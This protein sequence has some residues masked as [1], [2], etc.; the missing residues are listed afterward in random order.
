MLGLQFVSFTDR[1]YLERKISAS[2]KKR[3][4]K[5]ADSAL[6]LKTFAEMIYARELDL[7]IADSKKLLTQLSAS[8]CIDIRDQTATML[9]FYN[10]KY[11]MVEGEKLLE[12][13]FT[14]LLNDF[15]THKKNTPLLIRKTNMAEMV[16]FFDN[17]E[18]KNGEIEF[19]E[20]DPNGTRELRSSAPQASLGGPTTSIITSLFAGMAK[21]VGNKIGADIFDTIFPNSKNEME[22]ILAALQ[23]NIKEIFREE[24]DKQTIDNLNYQICGII[25]Y[26]QETYIPLKNDAGRDKDY[27]ESILT[28]QNEKMY[29]E[30]MALLTG[31][32]Y[33]AKGIAYLV[34]GANTH[35]SI[36]QEMAD[37]DPTCSDPSKSSYMTTYNMRLSNYIDSLQSATDEVYSSRLTY[38][39]SLEESTLHGAADDHWWFKDYWVGYDSPNY[40]NSCD[41]CD[42]END[43]KKKANKARDDY[44]ETTFLPTISND[45]KPYNDTVSSWTNI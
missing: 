12:D 18:Y 41:C 2:L 9:K 22:E 35:L 45:L 7:P 43:A 36:I 3:G 15:G 24:L 17:L 14:F 31:E 6:E 27:L 42:C 19:R 16:K 10:K 30:V 33:R 21:A 39:G 20:I 5:Y 4:S 28:S 29:T 11:P 25:S 13:N 32:R 38:L 8:Q 37:I 23:I 40:Y 44:N 1:K 26:M 34:L